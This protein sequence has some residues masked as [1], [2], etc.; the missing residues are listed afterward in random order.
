MDIALAFQASGATTTSTTTLHHAMLLANH[1]GLSAAILDHSL[2]ATNSD[3]L[4]IRL[5][6]LNIPFMTYSGYSH[7]AGPCSGVPHLDKPA[8]HATLVAAMQSLVH[9]WTTAR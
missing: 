3:T 6:E 5:R 1:D 4:C 9:P 2:G 8:T 7:I